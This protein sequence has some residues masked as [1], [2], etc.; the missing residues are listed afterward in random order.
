MMERGFEDLDL[1]SASKEIKALAEQ[2]FGF[3]EEVKE[4][5]GQLAQS[6]EIMGMI[7]EELITAMDGLGM[8]S[9]AGLDSVTLGRSARSFIK[10]V[11]FNGLS[12]YIEQ[13]LNESLEEYGS[14]KFD[15][16]K[17]KPLVDQAKQKMLRESIPLQE[18]LPKG[19]EVKYTDIITVRTKKLI[20]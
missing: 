9:Y 3:Y 7:K 11:D 12:N 18:A 6:E 4:L 19:I 13:T 1:L 14:F 17:L 20:E 8:S 5:K 10:V 16:D 15:N 2:Y